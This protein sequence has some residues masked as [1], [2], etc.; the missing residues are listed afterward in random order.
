LGDPK[1]SGFH[2]CGARPMPGVPY[3]GHH[4]ATAYQTTMRKF[5]IQDDVDNKSSEDALEVLDDAINS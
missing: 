4:A 5:N 2:F 1:K 3:C